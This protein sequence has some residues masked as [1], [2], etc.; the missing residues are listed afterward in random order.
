MRVR[1]LLAI[2]VLLGVGAVIAQTGSQSQRIEGVWRVVEYTTTGP[3]ARVKAQPQP[4]LLIFTGKHYSFMRVT[5]DEPRPPLTDVTKMTKE[6]IIAVYQ[7]FAAN[8][9]TYEVSGSTLTTWPAVAKDPDVMRAGF[10]IVFSF[11]LDGNHLFLNAL[12]N[13]NGPITNPIL[14]KAAR[15][16]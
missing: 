2:G 10:S 13:S 1:A 7:P 8:A 3:N 4:G 14:V 16:E 9:G 15:V 11:K 6:Q 5:S 12:R